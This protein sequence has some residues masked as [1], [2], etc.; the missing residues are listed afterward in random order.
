MGSGS[1]HIAPD[2]ADA[3]RRWPA[4]AFG[5][6]RL[7]CLGAF[8]FLIASVMAG[9]ATSTPMLIGARVL[10]SVGGAT[11]APRSLA[12]VSSRFPPE[13]R[14]RAL[15][16][17]AAFS[18]VSKAIAPA[19]GGIA[20]ELWSW[21]EVFFVNVPILLCCAVVGPMQAF[22]KSAGLRRLPANQ[23]STRLGGWTGCNCRVITTYICTAL[24]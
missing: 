22:R 21:R 17:W 24:S 6:R 11:L 13:Q 18:G 2:R 12:I 8:V 23:F 1:L 16:Q 14:G 5:W 3:D 7:L 20:I 19:L 10:Q 15:G 4:D 9:L